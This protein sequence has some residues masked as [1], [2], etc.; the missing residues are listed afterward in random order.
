MQLTLICRVDHLCIQ[1]YK[2]RRETWMQRFGRMRNEIR[3]QSIICICNSE[4]LSK[5]MINW[6]SMEGFALFMTLDF[7]K[8]DELAT[9][10]R[11][12][13]F[14]SE[15]EWVQ[16]VWCTWDVSRNGHDK[17]WEH[18][19]V[20]DRPAFRELQTIEQ[21]LTISSLHISTLQKKLQQ[22]LRFP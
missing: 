19:L 13:E 16:N 8:T 10:T 21:I 4:K 7:P 9:T 18:S 3:L 11:G 20:S 12:K 5:W 1:I 15:K 17:V 22:R 14:G 2:S 6:K